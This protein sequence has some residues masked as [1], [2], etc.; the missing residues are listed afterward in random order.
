MTRPSMIHSAETAAPTARNKIAATERNR[1]VSFDPDRLAERSKRDGTAT[2][3][4]N[5]ILDAVVQHREA[6]AQDA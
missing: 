4:E 1:A 5:Q 6:S 3:D 2:V